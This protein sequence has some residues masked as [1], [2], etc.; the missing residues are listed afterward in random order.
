MRFITE[1]HVLDS[2]RGTGMRFITEGHELDF[3]QRDRNEVYYGGT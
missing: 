3:S 2:H 1:G